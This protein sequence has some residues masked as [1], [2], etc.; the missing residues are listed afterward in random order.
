[1]RTQVLNPSDTKGYVEACN[2]AGAALRAGALVIFPTETVYGVAASAAQPEALARLRRL[3]QTQE[4]RPFTVHLGARAE[5]RRYIRA[6]SLLLR[7][8]AQRGWPGPMTLVTQEPNPGET[9]I[10]AELPAE[11]LP[12]IFFE[13]TVGLRCPDHDAA[14]RLLTAAGGC[15]VA[16]SAN[17]PGRPPP[18]DFAAAV[19]DLEPHVDWALDAGPTRYR[20][21]STV[22]AVEGERWRIVR[23]GAIDART[24]ARWARSEILFVC[25]GNSCR[26]PMAEYLFRQALA[27]ALGCAPEALADRGYIVG[28]AGAA[29]GPGGLISAGSREELAKRGLDGTAHRSRPLTVELIQQAS[30]IFGMTPDHCAAVLALVPGASDR[31][32]LLDVGGAIADP[33]GGGP[34][35][36]A[37]SAQAIEAAVRVRLKEM[38]DED[39]R[40]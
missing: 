18:Q 26:S 2:E 13:G 40:W 19:R 34:E 12:E 35:D 39:L 17:L 27:E 5:A 21:A 11:Q 1:M 16:S 24:V 32:R 22:V 36:Y 33:I 37:R 15:V 31:V 20:A 38:L 14:R 4:R 25:T 7:R 3:K 28:S 10:A 9:E 6:P 23:E 30:H 8:L 29:A